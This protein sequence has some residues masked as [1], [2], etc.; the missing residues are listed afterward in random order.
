[1]KSDFRCPHCSHDLDVSV[2]GRV[3]MGTRDYTFLI[4]GKCTNCTWQC[5]VQADAQDA[6]MEKFS[7]LIDAEWRQHAFAKAKA[8]L[9]AYSYTQ[10]PPM[11]D[12][13]GDF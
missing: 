12:T 3:A 9:E 10:K 1:M 13:Y 7:R 2:E 6:A 8:D 5:G 4:R 11:P